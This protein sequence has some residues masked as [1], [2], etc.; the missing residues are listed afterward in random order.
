MSVARTLY[1]VIT[2]LMFT[3]CASEYK[4]H[5]NSSVS[6]LDGK[7]LF[8]KVPQGGE[9]INVDSAEV[10]HG[11]FK[12]QGEID[13]AVIASLYMDEQSIL[14]LV[15][16]SG[17]IQIQIDNGRLT[18]SGTPLNDVLYDF[19][20]KKNSLDDRAYEV[21]R[22]ESRMIMDGMNHDSI[23]V[24]LNK[25]AELINAESDRL[26]TSFITKNYDNVLGAGVFMLLTSNFPYPILNPQ[27]ET[28]LG[29][30]TPYFLEN[31][32]VKEYVKIATENME[33]LREEEQQ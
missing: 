22:L 20:S 30:G 28:V 7:M 32:Y 23:L 33:K 14:P 11:L 2:V 9:M 18:V 15:M 5:G 27:I 24:I 4:I 3:S 31:A 26:I 1:S 10:V 12:M 16:E 8:V 29:M 19:V 13:S 21:E 6:R 25:E 17:N